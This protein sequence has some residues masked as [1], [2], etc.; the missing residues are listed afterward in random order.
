MAGINT[1]QMIKIIP[2]L[3]G[4][5]FVERTSSFNDILQITSP[6][7][8]KIISRL[9]R[10]EPIP[11]ENNGGEENICDFNDNGSSPCKV[12]YHGSHNSYEESHNSNSTKVWDSANEHLFCVLILNTPGAARRV[13]LNF[14]PRNDQP[15]NGKQAWLA[16]KNKY[17]NT[18]RQCR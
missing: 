3:D 13:L 18:S 15:G 7:L 8:S 10:P 9:E 17:Q 14:E 4:G 16:L 11:R 6:F 1:L 5:N 2:K 12:T